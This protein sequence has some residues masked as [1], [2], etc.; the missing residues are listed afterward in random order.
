MAFSSMFRSFIYEMICVRFEKK[1]E[2][3]DTNKQRATET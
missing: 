3:R 2:C 1:C